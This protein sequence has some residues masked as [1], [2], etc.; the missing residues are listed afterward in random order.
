M[1]KKGY[2]YVCMYVC[3]CMDGWMGIVYTFPGCFNA[4]VISYVCMY[5]YGWVDSYLIIKFPSIKK[6]NKKR[7]Y[8]C[9]YVCMYMY[10][11]VDSYCFI[12]TIY[13]WMGG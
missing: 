12:L 1:N 6:M 3:T 4:V 2:M 13:V 9:M 5:M 10:G 7:L 11:W 8:V